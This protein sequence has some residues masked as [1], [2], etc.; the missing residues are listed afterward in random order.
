MMKRTPNGVLFALV[1]EMR[2]ERNDL[3]RRS[4]AREAIPT[5]QGVC[6]P[7]PRG[8]QDEGDEPFNP[9]IID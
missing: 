9:P 4:W 3:R 6:K 7:S 8:T 2:I 5:K 1:A